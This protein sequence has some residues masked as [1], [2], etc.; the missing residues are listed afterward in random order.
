MRKRIV[1]SV[2]EDLEEEVRSEERHRGTERGKTPSNWRESLHAAAVTTDGERTWIS[3]ALS[4]STTIIGPPHLGQDQR[5]LGPA[6]E[7]FAGFAVS[8]RA[9]GRKVAR[10]RPVCGWPG[11]RS[12]EC[13]RNLPEAGAT[14]S[15]AR[16]HREIGSSTSV[17]CWRNRANET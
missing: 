17:R 8:R 7:A 3:A 5:S 13:A 14:G 10:W 11:C 4:L 12:Y 6:V 16:T 9:V 1:K 15:G 2:V